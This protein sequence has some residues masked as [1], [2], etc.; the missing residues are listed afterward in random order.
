MSLSERLK[1][2]EQKIGTGCPGDGIHTLF[3]PED[4]TL[5]DLPPC[6]RCGEHHTDGC[7]RFILIGH[8][9]PPGEA[10]R[11]LVEEITRP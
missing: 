9:S 7:I 3:V 4:G 8:A 2:L 11:P 6:S 10:P 5:P 1:R